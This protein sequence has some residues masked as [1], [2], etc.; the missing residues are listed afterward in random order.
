MIKLSHGGTDLGGNTSDYT[1]TPTLGEV[2]RTELSLHCQTV[3]LDTT[4]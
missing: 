4:Q 2:S 1:A 3:R